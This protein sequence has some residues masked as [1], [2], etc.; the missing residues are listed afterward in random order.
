M[1]P[2]S[3][4]L[5]ASPEQHGHREQTVTRGCQGPPVRTRSTWR[6]ASWP[7]LTPVC[8]VRSDSAG[9]IRN[10][11]CNSSWLLTYLFSQH[12]AWESRFQ[13][14][15]TVR[16]F[17]VREASWI[18]ISL[19]VTWIFG[20]WGNTF[21]S[22]SLWASWSTSTLLSPAPGHKCKALYQGPQK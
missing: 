10:T 21:L 13:T 8:Q 7:V 11:T 5:I 15:A 22:G 17:Y 6:D 16:H 9:H 14:W 2:T 12:C 3:V 1:W 4:A 20:R 18:L 19:E